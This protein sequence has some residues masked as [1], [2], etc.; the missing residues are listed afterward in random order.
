LPRTLHLDAANPADLHRAADLL[1]AGRLVAFAT[2]TVYGLGANALS[3]EAVAAIFAAKQRP[4]WDPLIVHLA[5]AAQLPTI[6]EIPAALRPRI[7]QLAQSFWPGP[8]T[9]L[10]PRKPKIPDAVTAGRELVGVRIPAHPAAQA[11][12]TA[13]NIPIAAPS[14]NTF[15][16]TSPTTAEHVL[17]DLDGRIDAVFDAGPTAIGLES[18][19]L[20]PTQT[21]MVLYRP[22]A[23]TAAQLTA[24]TGVAV[25]TFVPEP[26]IASPESLPSPGVGIRHYAPRAQLLLTEP[27]PAAL[28]SALQLAPPD[29]R[30]AVLLPTGWTLTTNKPQVVYPWGNWD[31]PEQLAARL[32]AGLRL[33]DDQG[34][35]LIFA[36]L[37][38]PGGLHDAI[39]D[40]LQ[41]AA[42]TE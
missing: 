36:P 17:A 38:P 11:L 6:V 15:G 19:V 12:L 42:R 18:T 14:A 30:I 2:E 13:A 7:L 28:D 10:L 4:A 37:P 8:L 32:F 1:R 34:A 39:R 40:R 20:D 23:I 3:P 21:P 29:S 41:K 27:T 26:Q 25:H 16:H 33:L 31:D 35:T 24:A 9:L 22:G 5:A